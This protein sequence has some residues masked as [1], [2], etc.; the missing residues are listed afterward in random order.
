MSKLVTIVISVL[1]LSSCVTYNKCMD[2]FG[3]RG[4]T[5]ITLSDTLDHETISPWDSLSGFIPCPPMVA[6]GD[7]STQTTSNGDRTTET[8]DNG[9]AQIT[10]WY[11]QYKKAIQ[12]QVD[13][14]PDTIKEKI[15][16]YIQGEC[17]EVVIVD[18]DKASR[19]VWFWHRYQVFAGW[20]LIFLVIGFIVWRKMQPHKTI[21][22]VEKDTTKDN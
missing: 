19:L 16:I 9:K 17:P 20:A 7:S 2:K 12:Y 8:S 6:D 11:N 10:Y 3:E 13:C 21:M 15:P 18:P 22:Y 1:L 5:P 14:L 4:T